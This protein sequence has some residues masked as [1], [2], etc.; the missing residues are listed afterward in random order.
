[1][2]FPLTVKAPVRPF[3]IGIEEL[4]EGNRSRDNRSEPAETSA[5]FRLASRDVIDEVRNRMASRGFVWE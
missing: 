4:W 5:S 1:M 2:S 3:S